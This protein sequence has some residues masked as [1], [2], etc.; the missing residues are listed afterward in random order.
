[1]ARVLQITKHLHVRD[2]LLTTVSPR[3][4]TFST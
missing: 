2:I 4:G 3:K 1:V